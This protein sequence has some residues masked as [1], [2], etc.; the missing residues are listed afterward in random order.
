MGHNHPDPPD[1]DAIRAGIAELREKA[2]TARTGNGRDA[3][4]SRA[5]TLEAASF[6]IQQL[7]S[8]H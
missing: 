2:K 7:Q 1:L 3:L 6:I 4:L 8:H 5:D